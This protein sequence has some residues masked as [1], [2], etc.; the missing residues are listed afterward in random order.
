MNCSACG[1]SNP[2]GMRFCGMC[3]APLQPQ[4]SGRE[5]RRVS[6]VFIDLASFSRL[7]HGFDP[8][9]LRDLA[10]EVLTVVAGVIED[11]RRLTW[12]HS[13]ATD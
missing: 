10:D 9:E 7:T 1:A 8:E 3:G 12:T 4:V 5:R 13:A 6:V 2:T 11:Y